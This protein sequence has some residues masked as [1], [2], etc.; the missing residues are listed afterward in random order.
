MPAI[1]AR[2]SSVSMPIPLTP[3]D[4]PLAFLL[5]KSNCWLSHLA[6]QTDPKSGVLRRPA[7]SRCGDRPGLGHLTGTECRAGARG[8]M[9][10]ATEVNA[11][12]RAP[13]QNSVV[14]ATYRLYAVG[15]HNH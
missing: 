9:G 12:V 13:V 11:E 10:S 15:R 14:V 5:G 2:A 4:A 6:S 7:R 3:C 1:S 8:R